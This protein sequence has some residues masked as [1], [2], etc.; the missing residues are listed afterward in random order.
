MIKV[1]TPVQPSQH[2]GSPEVIFLLPSILLPRELGSLKTGRFP[3]DLPKAE[4]YFAAML[5][6][7]SFF[8]L[9]G[10][11]EDPRV[12]VG[13]SRGREGDALME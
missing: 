13:C 12:Q 9:W 7:F 5:L 4:A 10:L 1:S 8:I 11:R 3:G 6:H 2:P